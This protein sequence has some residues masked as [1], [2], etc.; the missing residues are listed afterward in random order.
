MNL[1]DLTKNQ[2]KSIFTSI[3]IYTVLAIAIIVLAWTGSDFRILISNIT[4]AGTI[5]M[6]FTIAG[7]MYNNDSQL[8]YYMVQYRIYANDEAWGTLEG[9]IQ[10]ATGPGITTINNLTSLG[11]INDSAFTE[12]V[13][14]QFRI[15]A[16]DLAANEWPDPSVVN[17]PEGGDGVTWTTETVKSSTIGVG[18]KPR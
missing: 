18:S 11:I 4:D 8:D 16:V 3:V 15:Y 7:L 6:P 9:P 10:V 12:G 5:Y 1:Q 2:T 14:Y 13:K 17:I